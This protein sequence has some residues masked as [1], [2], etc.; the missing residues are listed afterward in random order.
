[1]TNTMERYEFDGNTALAR[2]HE[3]RLSVCDDEF[4][5]HGERPSKRRES[6]PSTASGM[7]ASQVEALRVCVVVLVIGVALMFAAFVGEGAHE[8]I[9]SRR[10][11]SMPT[12]TISVYPGETLWGVAQ[13]HPVDGVSTKELVEWLE[14]RNDL[15]SSLLTPGQTLLIPV[16]GK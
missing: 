13:D 8:A 10:I 11:S 9:A 1:M 3:P 4:S 5:Y 12:E 14:W 15:S 2:Q 7:V 6:H 16:V